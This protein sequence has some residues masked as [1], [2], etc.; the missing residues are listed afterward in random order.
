MNYKD[1]D[2]DLLLRRLNN[3]YPQG[4]NFKVLREAAC[5]IEHLL[6]VDAESA[7]TYR[8]FAKG[9]LNTEDGD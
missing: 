4:Y 8:T 3:D 6:S 5:V 7:N 2:V 9:W 1:V